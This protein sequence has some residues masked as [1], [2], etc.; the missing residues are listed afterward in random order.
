M[1]VLNDRIVSAYYAIK[2]N[3]D[4]LDTFKAR[5][6][7]NLGVLISATPYFYYPAVEPT[8]KACYNISTIES[9]PRVDILISY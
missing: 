1:V 8:G 7:G 4:T 6:M 5:E 2:I 9:I 3:A